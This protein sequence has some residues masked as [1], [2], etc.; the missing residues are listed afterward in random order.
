MG[1]TF[2]T[3]EALTEILEKAGWSIL[4]PNVENDEPITHLVIGQ[5][6]ALRDL[7][8]YLGEDYELWTKETVSRHGLS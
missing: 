1:L 5:E 8:R 6:A 3:I 7:G 2:E 4:S